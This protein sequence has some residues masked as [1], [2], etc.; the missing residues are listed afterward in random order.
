MKKNEN[1]QFWRIIF[2]YAIAFYHLNKKYD[3]DTAGYIA[4]EF[5]FM[6]SGYLLLA[7]FEKDES[8]AK[9]QSVLDYTLRRFRTYF[10]YTCF[11]L[12]VALLAVGYH[13][14]FSF[15]EYLNGLFTHLPELFLINLLGFKNGGGISFNDVTWYMSALLICGA[16][17]WGA[18]R[19]NKKLFIKTAPVISILLYVA[20]FMIFGTSNCHS[21]YVLGFIS[22]GLLH[23]MAGMTLG[24]S[25]YPIAALIREKNIPHTGTIAAALF[26]AAGVIMPYFIYRSPVEAVLIAMLFAGVCLAFAGDDRT[27]L[28]KRPLEEF[29][30]CTVMIY[31]SHEV[32]K[33]VVCLVFKAPSVISYFVYFVAVTVYSYVSNK[34]ITKAMSYLKKTWTSIR[35][36]EGTGSNHD[37]KAHISCQ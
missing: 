8:R 19:L 21:E 16:L 28:P 29:A 17:I 27:I 31:L 1:I 2:T 3:I 4:V 7:E 24:I 25:A 26:M 9:R 33:E 10:P 22:A 37:K 18:L 36:K 14:H 20:M 11:A 13:R 15:M 32:I 12:F 6:V 34:I 5:F 30:S 23:G 35:Q